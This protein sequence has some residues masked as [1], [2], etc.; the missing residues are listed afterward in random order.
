MACR[1]SR[2]STACAAAASGGEKARAITVASQTVKRSLDERHGGGGR[3]G[4]RELGEM[5][6]PPAARLLLAPARRRAAVREAP[7]QVLGA[8]PPPPRPLPPPGHAP[9]PPP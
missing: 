2:R 9:A 1:I 7:R 6:L 8:R 5:R 4:L 3:Y